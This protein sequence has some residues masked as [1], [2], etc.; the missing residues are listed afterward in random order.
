MINIQV[1]FL[2][3]S[4]PIMNFNSVYF[5]RS[6]NKTAH[7]HTFRNYMNHKSGIRD[8]DKVI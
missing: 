1:V 5:P 2:A 3:S 8:R 4:T 6:R 7:V